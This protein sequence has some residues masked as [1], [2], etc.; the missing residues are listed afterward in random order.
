MIKIGIAGIGFMGWIHYLAYQ[1]VAGA[2]IVALCEQ[3][4]KRLAGDWRDIQGNFGPRGE[5]IDVSKMNRYESL[6]ELFADPCGGYGRHLPPPVGARQCR[7]PSPGTRQTCALR[8]AH[9]ADCRGLPA[10]GEGRRHGRN[11]RS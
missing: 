9:G 4:R 2:R 3:N 11:A 5:L 1:R 10:H 6:D 7:R 8:K